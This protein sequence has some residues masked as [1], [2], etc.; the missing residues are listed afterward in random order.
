MAKS[1]DIIHPEKEDETPVF[2]PKQEGEMVIEE[3][4]EGNGSFYLVLGIVAI[5]LAVAISMYI[6][7]KDNIKDNESAAVAD[8]ATPTQE[9]TQLESATAEQSTTATAVASQTA[10]ATT[11]GDV[12]I[13]NGNGINGEGKRI[14]ELLKTAG[15]NVVMVNNASKTYTETIIYY[16]TNQEALAESLKKSLAEEYTATIQK[17]D[18]IVGVY[19]AVVALGSK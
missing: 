17:S 14:S 16:K 13:A 12:R 15:Y 10:A 9:A 7:F 19:D 2:E 18:S 6:L 3:P 5:V 1:L 8:S 4:K 11:E